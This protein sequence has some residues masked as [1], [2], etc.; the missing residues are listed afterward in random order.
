MIGACVAFFGLRSGA[1]RVL[2]LLASIPLIFI[3][4]VTRLVMLFGLA[5]LGKDEWAKYLYH[6]WIAVFQFLFVVGIMFVIRWLML[7]WWP[8]RGLGVSGGMKSEAL[9]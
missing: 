9:L 7:K 1:K 3:S 6:D 4:A 8:I 2:L 5:S